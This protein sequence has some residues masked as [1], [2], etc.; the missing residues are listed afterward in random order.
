MKAMHYSLLYKLVLYT[1]N[2][3]HFSKI[4]NNET[5][6]YN[7]L[8][9]SSGKTFKKESVTNI[10]PTVDII[11]LNAGYNS[12]YYLEKYKKT[13]IVLHSTVGVL[14]GDIST[15]TK[16]NEH[17]SVSYVI[18]RMGHI[19]ETFSPEYWS[20]HLGTGSAG[21]NTYCSRESIAI[22]L[23]NYG[24]LNMVGNNLETVYSRL[25]Y[26]VD[27]KTKISNP[28]VYCSL[29]DINEYCKLSSPFKDKQYFT[30]FTN[31]QY[32]SLKALL[33]F[34]CTKFNINHSLLP[35]N[36]RYSVFTN[37]TAKKYNGIC[38]HL[39][40]RATGKWDLSPDFEWNNII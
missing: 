16:K 19:Y 21:G 18:D 22:E 23:S 17:M 31:N 27:G 26:T 7:T 34:L 5:N 25:K 12:Y 28:D 29:S 3:M 33:S 20:Y 11:K 38:S 2:T 1:G 4:L 6:F 30:T 32:N 14:S 10:A 39:N 36:Q 8:K 35:L 24:P 13:K 37:A 9:D 15:V 40:F